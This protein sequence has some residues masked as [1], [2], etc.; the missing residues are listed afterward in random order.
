MILFLTCSTFL[1]EDVP[2][3]LIKAGGDHWSYQ[4]WK[5]ILGDF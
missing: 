1:A 2:L 3:L 4:A 5:G